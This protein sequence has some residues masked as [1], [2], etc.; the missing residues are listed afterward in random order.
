MHPIIKGEGEGLS[1]KLSE[2]DDVIKNSH[3]LQKPSWR[4]PVQDRILKNMNVLR[5]YTIDFNHIH[6]QTLSSELL[7]D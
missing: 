4:G 5:I 7:P 2:K 6:P 1:L 3:E